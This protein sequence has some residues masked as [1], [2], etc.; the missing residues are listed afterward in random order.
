MQINWQ[1][2][3]FEVRG[4]WTHRWLFMAPEYILE[5]DGT[6]AARTGGPILRPHL[7]AMLEDE[8]G[9]LHHIE[10]EL[11]SVLGI[12]PRCQVSV[13]GAPVDSQRVHVRNILNPLLFLIVV[14]STLIMLYLGPEVLQHYWPF[15]G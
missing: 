11:F 1:D 8:D 2:H 12:R 13:D 10:A 4:D 7:E 3:Q 6:E 5:I 15:G 14:V 9:E